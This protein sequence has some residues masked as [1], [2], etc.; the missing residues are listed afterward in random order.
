MQ[1]IDKQSDRE[2]WNPAIHWLLNMAPAEL[3]AKGTLASTINSLEH[4]GEPSGVPNTDPYSNYQMGWCVGDSPADKWRKYAPVWFA[5][6]RTRQGMLLAHYLPRNDLPPATRARIDG[7][8]GKLANAVVYV[9]P[10]PE[11]LFAACLDA[12]HQGRVEIIKAATKRAD[13]AV[14][15]AHRGWDA[16]AGDLTTWRVWPWG[17]N[18]LGREVQ[19]PQCPYRFRQDAIEWAKTKYRSMPTDCPGCKAAMKEPPRD[20]EAY[21]PPVAV[22]IDDGSEARWSAEYEKRL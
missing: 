15:D 4:G 18:P 17:G 10:N 7:A 14:R 16:V 12:K 9:E 13:G 5:L 3:G 21:A 6:S 11:R 20:A 19:C 8:F 22:Q 2:L 1:A